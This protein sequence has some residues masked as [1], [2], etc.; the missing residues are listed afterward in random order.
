MATLQ[1]KKLRCIETESNWGSDKAYLVVDGGVVWGPNK[2]NDGQRRTV[3]VD[4]PVNGTALIELWDDDKPDADDCLG[5]WEVHETERGT[6]RA[7][8]NE[9]DAHYELFYQVVD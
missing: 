2:I 9:D 7:F 4:V 8:F 1:L 5:K 6:R 3:N